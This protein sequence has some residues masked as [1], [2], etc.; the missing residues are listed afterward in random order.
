M[1]PTEPVLA[2][3]SSEDF[4]ELSPEVQRR[5]VAMMRAE[6]PK[7]AQRIADREASRAVERTGRT[8]DDL[9]APQAE[10][11]KAA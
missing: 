4:P 2:E 10:H 9:R 6:L 5:I 3:T 8:A 1:E 7:A 11:V